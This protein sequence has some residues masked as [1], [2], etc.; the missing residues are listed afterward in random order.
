MVD[1]VVNLLKVV[2]VDSDA[3]RDEKLFDVINQALHEMVNL[4]REGYGS[5]IDL[6]GKLDDRSAVERHT[7]CI[8]RGLGFK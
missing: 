1:Y 3:E 8:L 5:E 4:I 2:R 6:I 7:E